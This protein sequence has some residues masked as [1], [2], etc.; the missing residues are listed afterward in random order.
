[1]ASAALWLVFSSFTVVLTVEASVEV[2][3]HAFSLP[4]ARICQALIAPGGDSFQSRGR[5]F[6]TRHVMLCLFPVRRMGGIFLSREMFVFETDECF[7]VKA[8]QTSLPRHC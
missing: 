8:G 5:R 6:L 4:P 3:G 2:R 1:M 7:H